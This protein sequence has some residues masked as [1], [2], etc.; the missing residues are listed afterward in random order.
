MQ[1]PP[2]TLVVSTTETSAVHIW[3]HVKEGAPKP[4]VGLWSRIKNYAGPT[5]VTNLQYKGAIS[6]ALTETE[7]QLEGHSF[8]ARSFSQIEVVKP[9]LLYA[10]QCVK[11]VPAM[12]RTETRFAY[13][14][15]VRR[16]RHRDREVVQQLSTATAAALSCSARLRRAA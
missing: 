6:E 1:L 15:R 5:V 8:S 13:G 4:R 3:L 14:S 12:F 9:S 10:F 16:R 7:K 11:F 2:T